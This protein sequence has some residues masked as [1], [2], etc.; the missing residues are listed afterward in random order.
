MSSWCSDRSAREFGQVALP[1]HEMNVFFHV[2]GGLQQLAHNQFWDG[3]RHPD[4]ESASPSD[5][6][7]RCEVHQLS[8]DVEDVVCIPKDDMSEVVENQASTAPVEEIVPQ[9]LLELLYLSAERGRSQPERFS[10]AAEIVPSR[11]TVQK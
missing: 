3:L 6:P 1:A 10:P 7:P 11:A 4:V 5:R 9:S 8:P 2:Q